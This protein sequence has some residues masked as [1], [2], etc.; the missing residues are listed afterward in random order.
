MGMTWIKSIVDYDSHTSLQWVN[1]N[2]G[3]PDQPTLYVPF[4]LHQYVL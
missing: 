4:K 3:V 1:K 2:Y